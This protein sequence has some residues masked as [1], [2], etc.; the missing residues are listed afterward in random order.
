MAHPPKKFW[1]LVLWAVKNVMNLSPLKLPWTRRF[2]AKNT[3]KI[4]TKLI[5]FQFFCW[6][7]IIIKNMENFDKVAISSRIRLARNVSGFNFFTKLT[8]E[9]DA[10]FIVD[11]VSQVLKDFCDVDV[12]RLKNLSLEDCQALL[13]RHIISKGLIENKDISAVALSSDEHLIVMMNEED[14]IR[15]QCLCDGFNL[16]RPYREIKQFDDMLLSKID[17]AFSP[18]Y[19]FITS[20]PSNLGT[21]MR[22]SVMLFLPALERTGEIELLK[23]EARSIGN[24]VRGM[25]GEGSE[26]VGSFY[27]ISNQN[28]LGMS[29]K[30]ILDSVSDYVYQ[31]CQMELS[32]RED[33][34]S[35]DHDDLADEIFR[36]YGL[37]LNSRLLSEREMLEKLALIR[38]GDAVGFFKL[39]DMKAFNRLAVEASAGNLK[40]LKVYSRSTK[41]DH[42]R[43]EYIRERLEQ[44]I[45]RKAKI[46][47]N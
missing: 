32:A 14:H 41:E 11:T 38:F 18:E 6:C 33:I 20:C 15:E 7:D 45:I 26:N 40:S 2:V 12:L 8:N 37:L 25:Y 46:I 44:L 31:A 5:L 23:T 30:E 28:S 22:A 13:E 16:Y 29:E 39:K 3:R 43:S 34:L 47:P 1:K 4:E 36:A 24:T 10:E 42:I 19:G 27:Q 21:G 9:A 17:V 35:H